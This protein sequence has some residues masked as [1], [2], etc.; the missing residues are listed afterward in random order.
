MADPFLEISG[1][2]P[3]Q[4]EVSDLTKEATLSIYVKKDGKWMRQVQKGRMDGNTFIAT[5]APTFIAL[6]R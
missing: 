6:S 1:D 2:M 4:L 5:A 3:A